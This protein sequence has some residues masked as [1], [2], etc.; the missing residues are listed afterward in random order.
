MIATASPARE[1]LFVEKLLQTQFDYPT[2][3][4]S[5]CRERCFKDAM[6]LALINDPSFSLN[7]P[8]FYVQPGRC[9]HLLRACVQK[10]NVRS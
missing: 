8:H 1:H 5:W 7:L 6:W 9:A 10:L 2:I 3:C 4:A